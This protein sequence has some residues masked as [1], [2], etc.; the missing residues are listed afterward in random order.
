MIISEQ[1]LLNITDFNKSIFYMTDYKHTFTTI[2]G[3]MAIIVILYRIIY[4]GYP[5]FL[6]G[7][8]TNQ[9]HLILK[10]MTTLV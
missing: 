6:E 10:A 2:I 7:Y 3:I 4:I 5:I 8:N 9:L 1:L